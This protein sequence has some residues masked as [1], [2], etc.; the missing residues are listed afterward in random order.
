MHRGKPLPLRV[1]HL[2]IVSRHVGIILTRARNVSRQACA[3][4]CGESPARS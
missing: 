1:W 4:R 3:S 2:L